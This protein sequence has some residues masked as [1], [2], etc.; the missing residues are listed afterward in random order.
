MR[1]PVTPHEFEY[2]VRRLIT[3]YLIPPKNRS[4]LELG[5]SW[6]RSFREQ[7][8]RSV[9]AT[10]LHWVSKVMEI[11]SILDTAELSAVAS[12]E[13]KESRWGFWHQRTDFPERDDAEWIKHVVLRRGGTDAPEVSYKPVEALS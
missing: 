5:L 13:R 7:L 10:D 11:E 3:N 2:K 8:P 1:G 9:N 12:L 6:M 4:R